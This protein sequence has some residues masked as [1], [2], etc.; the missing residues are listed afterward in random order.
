M[1]TIHL[2]V[3]IICFN[4]TCYPALVG[5]LTPTGQYITTHAR[6]TSP[7]YGGDV[8]IV[9]DVSSPYSIHRVWTGKPQQRRLQRLH[10]PV[11]DRKGITGG[12]I[13]VMPDV[14]DKLIEC[15]AGQKVE[16]K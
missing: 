8:L 15:C 9:G 5:D 10:G 2:A 6:I 1:I 3:A 12:C 13:N 4:A 16:I 7:G 14:Y 11:K